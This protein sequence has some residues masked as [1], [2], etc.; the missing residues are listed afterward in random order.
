[1]VAQGMLATTTAL[2]ESWKLIAALQIFGVPI[3]VF[4][5]C[6]LDHS[7]VQGLSPQT[8]RAAACA[9]AA[10][11]HGADRASSGD[12]APLDTGVYGFGLGFRV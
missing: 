1:M 12:W 4:K 9:R 8:G 2:P 5:R 10:P 6:Q 11:L 3:V 7:S